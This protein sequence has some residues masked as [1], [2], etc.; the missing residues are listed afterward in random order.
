MRTNVR[1]PY[2]HS[3][4]T[5]ASATGLPRVR[6]SF[7]AEDEVAFQAR[8]DELLEDFAGW[9]QRQQPLGA[10]AGDARVALD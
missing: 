8:C 10:D 2:H 4:H 6:V 5:R 9:L 7:G 3:T 1:S